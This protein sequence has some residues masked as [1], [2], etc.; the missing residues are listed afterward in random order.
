[1]TK[2][3]SIL[4]VD[5]DAF[6]ASIAQRDHPQYRGKPVIVGGHSTKRGVVASASYE[7]RAFGVR[8]AMPLYKAYELCPQ[9][10]RV[11][12]EMEKYRQINH[13][14]QAIWERFAPVVEPVSFDEAY[15]DLTGTEKLLGPVE[16]VAY[17][18]Q[19]AVKAETGLICSVGGG[20]S[21]LLAKVASKAAKP[22]GVCLIPTGNEIAWLHPREVGV[23][24]GVGPHTQDRLHR[25]GI[26][27]IG[28]L[29]EVGLDFLVKHFGTQGTDLYAIA[30]GRDPRPVVSAAPQKSMGGEETF[31][32]DSND[33]VF[34]RRTILRIVCD[35]GYRLRC[36]G[37]LASTISA[38]IRYGKTF[39]TVERVTTLMTGIDDDDAFY[40][41]AWKLLSEAWD[42]KRSLRLVGA[43]LSNFKPNAQLSLFTTRKRPAA[44]TEALDQL[45][46]RYGAQAVIRG[47]LANSH[48][49]KARAKKSYS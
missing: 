8:S 21:K 24:P 15:L 46:S 20:S 37:L 32:E 11:A 49:K 47:S 4:H 33:P 9:A 26:K 40:E 22:A 14:L 13:Q 5:M 45:R 18:I 2:R 29:S 35:L 23:I 43:S 44:L 1:M 6:F 31:D 30:Q 19:A 38:K 28:Q 3:R 42:G 48:R 36:H 41:I 10:I 34:L 27:T 12:V 7:A 39:E 25:F 16:M 17:A